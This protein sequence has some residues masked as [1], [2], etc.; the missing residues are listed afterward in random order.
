VIFE[1][2][3]GFL[4][5]GLG[6][7]YHLIQSRNFRYLRH[8]V[9]FGLCLALAFSFRP[10]EAILLF[11]PAIL[12]STLLGMDE[13]TVSRGEFFGSVFIS[14]LA[15]GLSVFFW[16]QGFY[17]KGVTE[18]FL[19][20]LLGGAGIFAIQD[21]SRRSIPF[22]AGFVLFFFWFLVWFLPSS[23]KFYS[24][25]FRWTFDPSLK[26]ESVYVKE[27]AARF[28]EDMAR[29]LGGYPFLAVTGIALLR[30]NGSLAFRKRDRSFW[31]RPEVA[32]VC[33]AVFLGFLGV[34]T[35]R[36]QDC[37]FLPCF[38]T[39]GLILVGAA[40]S[41]KPNFPRLRTAL[42]LALAAFQLLYGWSAVFPDLERR[43]PDIDWGQ[44]Q[45]VVDHDLERELV[46]K[47]ARTIDPAMAARIQ[48]LIQNRGPK[49]PEIDSPP[50]LLLQ[51]KILYPRWQIFWGVTPSALSDDDRLVDLSHKMDFAVVGPVIGTPNLYD[52][53]SSTLPSAAIRAWQE[54]RLDRIGF[55]LAEKIHL[56]TLSGRSA[57]Y[58]LIKSVRTSN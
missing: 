51:A 34:Y 54:N 2:Y 57:D 11:S 24:W 21:K 35:R 31:R 5:F 48:L 15:G 17:P 50:G 3:V 33:G 55:T 40:L 1:P 49:Q 4:G 14:V 23:A 42:F 44:L 46:E 22:L 36:F 41:N 28:L 13:G 39:L 37:Y 6:A 43:L 8:S 16:H 56:A 26:Q 30:G 27:S 20:A 47:L 7:S 18:L 52:I 53:V 45:P 32:F 58:L 12:Q 19:A 38:T 25:A 29:V 10:F 9:A